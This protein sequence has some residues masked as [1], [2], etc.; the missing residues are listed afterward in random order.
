MNMSHHW[1]FASC[2]SIYIKQDENSAF[3]VVLFVSLRKAT[4]ILVVL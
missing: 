1:I 3:S 2:C 4:K